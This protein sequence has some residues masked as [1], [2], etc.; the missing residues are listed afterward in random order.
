MEQTKQ[1][2][3]YKIEVNNIVIDIPKD[4]QILTIQVQKN[5][6]CIWVLVNPNN[7]IETRHFE[8]YGTGHNIYCTDSIERKYINTFQLNDGDLVF[9][10]FEII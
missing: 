8:V 5:T 7:E 2:W 1:I 6:P 3:K 10:L 9:H 4:S